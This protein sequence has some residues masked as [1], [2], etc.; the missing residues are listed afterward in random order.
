MTNT[1]ARL[2]SMGMELSESFLVQFIINSLPSEYGPFQI[3]YNTIKDKWNVTE[4]QSMLIQ[5]E[6]RL[7]K[8]GILSI[9][10][11]GHQGAGKKP[12]KYNGKGKKRALNDNVLHVQIHK[13]EQKNDKYHF[14]KKPGH[15]QKDCLKHKA[16]FEKKG[17]PLVFVCFESNLTEVPYNTW[18]IDSGSTTHV[19]NTMQGFLMTQTIN[20]NE[21]FIFMGN[22][23]KAPVEAIGT[24]HLFFD[25]GHHLD[26]FQTLYVPTVSRNLV[27]LS[28]L[29]TVGY[30]FKFGN[31]CFSLFK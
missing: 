20:P 14:C 25:T 23:V 5:E 3:N 15:Y 31:G 18:W 8:Q 4:L 19:L 6:A 22:R 10:L 16:W 9:N 21:N 29:D 12:G 28:K 27:S 7:K 26:L 1:A 24:Y 13:K 11:M 17:K 30:S 2:R